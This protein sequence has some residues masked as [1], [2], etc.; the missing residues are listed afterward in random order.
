MVME[1]DL[2]KIQ[3]DNADHTVYFKG[4]LR[5]N[6]LDDF[7]KIK[8]FLLE[9]FDLESPCL[10]MNFVDLEY[11]NSAGMNTM[12]QF[13]LEVKDNTDK[14]I[15]VIGNDTILWQ[16]KSFNNL[17]ILWDKLEVEFK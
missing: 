2:F 14:I 13:I 17:K 7:S 10:I 11:M 4:T 15:K 3:Y 12:C 16:K 1:S 8:K 5:M 9:I 6:N